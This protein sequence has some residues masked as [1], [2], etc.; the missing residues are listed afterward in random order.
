[1]TLHKLID[2]YIYTW[3]T[4]QAFV[5]HFKIFYDNLDELVEKF[6]SLGTQMTKQCKKENPITVIYEMKRV[7]YPDLNE[8]PLQ[9][10]TVKELMNHE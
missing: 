7:L 4:L 5:G 1:M 10:L 9:G 6:H 2:D 3:Q 8:E